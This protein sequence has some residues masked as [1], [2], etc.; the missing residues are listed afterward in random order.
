MVYTSF[1]RN[2]ISQLTSVRQGEVV[3]ALGRGRGF[4]TMVGKW[5]WLFSLVCD[6]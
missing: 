4:I 1:G 2:P 5:N 3:V 6:I